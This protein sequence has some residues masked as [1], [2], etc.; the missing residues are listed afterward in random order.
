MIIKVLLLGVLTVTSY[1]PIPAQTKPTCLD[2]HYCETSIGENVSE[3][4]V[5]ISQDL[6]ESGTVHYGDC[7]YVPGIG[8][9]IVNDT[10]A[11][12]NRKAVDIFVY[13]KNEERKI[14]VRHLEIYLMKGGPIKCNISHIQSAARHLA[15]EQESQNEIE[16]SDTTIN[17][18]S[19]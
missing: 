16:Y 15:D 14:G 4:G 2:R 13:T 8:Y 5:A 3:M 7:L 18:E 9:R 17:S 11:R 10:M 6:L 19:Y 12:R 1:R